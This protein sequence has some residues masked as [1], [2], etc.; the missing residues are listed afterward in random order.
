M[1]EISD[2][3]VIA[4][5]LASA[6]MATVCGIF[7]LLAGLGVFPFGIERCWL[8]A[9]FCTLFFI[10]LAVTIIQKNP[11]CL[12]FCYLFGVL[13]AAQIGALFFTYR[14]VYPLFVAA[15][16]IAGA[17]V[18]PKTHYAKKLLAV[19]LVTAVG[20][21]ILFIESTGLLSVKVVLPA[22]AVYFGVAGIIY[23]ARRLK[24]STEKENE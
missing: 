1:T 13:T 4:S 22:E 15:L 14:C 2:K 10:S 21:L 23:A 16:P 6:A 5:E 18:S 8:A 19:S 20:A 12:F 11:I 24:N 3:K 7:L 17:G 9:V